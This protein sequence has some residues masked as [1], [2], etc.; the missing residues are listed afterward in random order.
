MKYVYMDKSLQYPL[1]EIEYQQINDVWKFIEN[2]NL[3]SY[4]LHGFRFNIINKIKER[5]TCDEFYNLEMIS[6]KLFWNLRYR[7]YSIFLNNEDNIEDLIGIKEGLYDDILSM[8][9][10]DNSYRSFI[11]KLILIDDNNGKYYYK[12]MEGS[13]DIFFKNQFNLYTSIIFFERDLYE[14]MMINPDKIIN[15][16][17]PGYYYEYDYP[18]PNLNYGKPFIQT[19]GYRIKRIYMMYY[20]EQAENNWFRLI[21]P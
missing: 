6:E 19:K 7:I 2:F 13:A 3:I 14:Q 9:Y 10:N 12:R 11:N 18:F 8:M 16:S 20:D 4:T 21:K 1:T 5:Y 17:I 15:I